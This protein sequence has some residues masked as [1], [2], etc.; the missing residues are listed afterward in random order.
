MIK[1]NQRYLNGLHVVI[2]IVVTIVSFAIAY[3]IRFDFSWFAP[4]HR[5][6]TIGVYY[7]T[8]K[9]YIPHSLPARN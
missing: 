3:Y 7:Y 9:D 5:P 8:L 2:D 4:K 1:E 6:G